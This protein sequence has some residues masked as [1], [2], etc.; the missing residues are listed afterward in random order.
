MG[1]IGMAAAYIFA[2]AFVFGAG[3]LGFFGNL[4]TSAESRRAKQISKITDASRKKYE[5]AF[6]KVKQVYNEIFDEHLSFLSQSIN[7]KLHYYFQD[8]EHQLSGFENPTS[9]Q[10]KQY[11]TALSEIEKLQTKLAEFDAELRS[12]HFSKYETV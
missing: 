3:L 7:Q 6:S 5:S 2:P 4:F 11:K 12:F 1:F 8:L 10:I 9:L